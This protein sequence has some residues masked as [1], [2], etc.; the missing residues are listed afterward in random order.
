L[1]LRFQGTGE[2]ENALA[3]ALEDANPPGVELAV[4]LT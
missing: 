2:S 4:A 1:A 3:L